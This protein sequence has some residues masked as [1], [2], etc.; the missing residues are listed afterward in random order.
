MADAIPSREMRSDH[1]PEPQK[2]HPVW[3][4]HPWP[5]SSARQQRQV[6]GGD[7]K[8]VVVSEHTCRQRH[9]EGEPDLGIPQ[10]EYRDVQPGLQRAGIQDLCPPT[11]E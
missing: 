3:L 6:P 8:Q 9:Q 10:T 2:S 7:Y 11:L 5:P 4:L 1:H